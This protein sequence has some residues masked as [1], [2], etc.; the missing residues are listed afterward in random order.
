MSEKYGFVYIW[1]DKKHVRFYIGC[2]WGR[3]DD[4]YICSSSWMKKAYK[5][6]PNDF[7]RRIISRVYSN[8]TDLLEEEY[9]WLSMIKP[10]ELKVRYYNLRQ[11]RWGHWTSDEDKKK[12][13]GE[14]IS[15]KTKA[16]MWSPEIREKYLK[17]MIGRKNYVS[18]EGLQRRTELHIKRM[19]DRFPKEHRKVRCKFGSEEY[20]KN[21]A[22]KTTERWKRV[23][24]KEIGKKISESLKKSKKIRSDNM[25]KLKWW[26]D[27]IINIRREFSP[28]EEWILGRI[29]K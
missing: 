9:R 15:E 19:E 26:N 1:F 3:E 6:R 25:S 10:E 17:G 13:I 2:H 14:K 7:K 11:H 20:Q 22:L 12:T 29:K 18:P 21:M 4:G 28:G 16:A 23:D 27:G 24:K 8:K 5:Y